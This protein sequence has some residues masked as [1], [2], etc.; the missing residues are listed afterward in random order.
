MLSIGSL[1]GHGFDARQR[2]QLEEAGFRLRRQASVY[3]G[4]QLCS[5]IDFPTGPALELIEVTDP[6]DYASV[7]P[8]GMAPFCPGIS[9]V[10]GDGSPAGLGDYERDFA[11]HEPYRFRVPYS[12]ATGPGAPG[13]HY[14]NFARP[15]VP[16]MF[17]WL[18]AFDHP[19]PAAARVTRHDNAVGGIVGFLFALEPEDLV[20]LANLAGQPLIEG[21]VRI[22]G[23]VI[24]A[25]GADDPPRP[26]PLRA[27]VLRADNLETVRAHA[28][29]AEKTRILGRPA[30]RIE[31]NPLAW[32]LLITA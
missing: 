3:E 27:V 7:L 24:T 26:F 28:P 30:L 16:G 1:Y 2:A 5:F 12:G 8:A 18:T 22:G 15:V 9:L 21:Q 11:G 29:S 31:T 20:G 4:S 14:L 32:D 19:K 13:W 23:V 17:I 6:S 25:I 10:V